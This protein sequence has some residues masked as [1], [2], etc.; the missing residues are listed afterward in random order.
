M[1]KLTIAI[2][3]FNGEKT[4]KRTLDSIFAQPFSVDDVDVIVCDNCSTDRTLEI[5]KPYESKVSIFKNESNLGGDKNFQ[6]C[7]E[8]SRSEYVWILGDDDSLTDGAIVGALD[9]IGKNHYAAI[10]VNYSLFNIKQNKEVLHKYLPLSHDVIAH[11]IS[12]FL[13]HTN[14]A[15]NF[16]S[17]VIHNKKLFDSVDA[18]NYFGTCWL[19]FAVILDYVNDNE[20]LIIAEPFVVNMGDSSDR[21][22]NRGG[23]AVRIINNLYTIVRNNQSSYFKPEVRQAMLGTI[24]KMLKYKIVSAK[25]LGLKLNVNLLK[26]LVNNFGHFWSFWLI[27]FVLLLTPNVVFKGIYNIYRPLLNKVFLTRY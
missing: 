6:L 11:D 27:D 23:V 7:V 18:T 26:D 9:R 14:L 4:I 10:F 13:E 3:T 8:R 25:R 1:K 24:R 5:L 19:Q 17:S 16:L 12:Q 15:A 22:F 20:T 21:E 2:P